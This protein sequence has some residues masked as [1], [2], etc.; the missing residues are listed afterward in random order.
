MHYYMT[1]LM[2]LMLFYVKYVGPLSRF[3]FPAYY[4][5]SEMETVVNIQIKVPLLLARKFSFLN[6]TLIANFQLQDIGLSSLG[7]FHF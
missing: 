3:C 7:T 6:H 1:P 4:Q 2:G 5:M